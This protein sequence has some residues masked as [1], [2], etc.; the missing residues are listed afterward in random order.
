MLFGTQKKGN[1]EVSLIVCGSLRDAVYPDRAQ[2]CLMPFKN[3]PMAQLAQVWCPDPTWGN[4]PKIFQRALLEC[5][6]W[7]VEMPLENST[8]KQHFGG[9]SMIVMVNHY[10]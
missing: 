4:H 2:Q 5:D 3:I 9:F 10:G 1:Q 7:L 6:P 8:G